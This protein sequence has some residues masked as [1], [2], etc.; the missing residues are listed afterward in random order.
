MI[1]D[2]L[3]DNVLTV[4]TDKRFNSSPL[5]HSIMICISDMAKKEVERRSSGIGKLKIIIP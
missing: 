2:P 3:T 1:V 4:S 5:N